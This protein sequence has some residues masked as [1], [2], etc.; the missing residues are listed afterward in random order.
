M[1]RNNLLVNLVILMCVV[2]IM[3]S[4]L[5]APSL[6]QIGQYYALDESV[7]QLLISVNL[8]GV[9]ISSLLYGSLSD[10]Y[11]RRSVIL[12]GMSLFCLGSFACLIIP[13]FTSFVASRFIQGCGE[14]VAVSV[15]LAAIYD[16]IKGND[17]A[18]VISRLCMVISL[19]PGIAPIVGGYIATYSTWYMALWIIAVSSLFLNA[20]LWKKFPE[21]LLAP[22][23]HSVPRFFKEF[24]RGTLM[25][26][27]NKNFMSCALVQGLTIGILW[28]ELANLPFIFIQSMGLKTEFYGYFMAMSVGAYI[29]GAKIN[30]DIIGKVECF[31]L[32]MLGVSL[33]LL[34]GLLLVAASYYLTLTPWFVLLLS[35]PGSIGIGF[36]LGNAMALA[37]DSVKGSSG[38]MTSFIGG[39]EMLLGGISVVIVGVFYDGTMMPIGIIAS[40]FMLFNLAL[41]FQG[42]RRLVILTVEDPAASA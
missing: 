18:K 13:N 14:G 19:A 15:G 3:G 31:N 27:K 10:N 8:F 12:T 24:W 26:V 38:S 20:I 33:K 30:Q 37:M 28:A 5:F 42:R 11:G 32:L 25:L 21:T 1:S 23:R 9:G 29:I 7:V 4:D 39:T 16:R 36:I 6:P 40:L 2:T 41:L 35:L 17:Y 34:S 22:H